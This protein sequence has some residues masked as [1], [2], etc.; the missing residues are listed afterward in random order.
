MLLLAI[1]LYIITMMISFSLKYLTKWKNLYHKSL[2]YF[3]TFHKFILFVHD[4]FLYESLKSST[5]VRSICSSLIA[6]KKDRNLYYSTRGGASDWYVEQSWA[7]LQLPGSVRHAGDVAGP[8]QGRGG[9]EPEPARVQRASDPPP[10]RTARWQDRWPA[11]MG[12]G[13][14]VI[15]IMCM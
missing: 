4:N 3:L 5:P 9:H 14:H 13:L 10:G 15:I 8:Q 1:V 2:V 12:H 7:C 6:M 11:G